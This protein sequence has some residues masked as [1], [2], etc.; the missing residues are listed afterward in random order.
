MT[1]LRK[2][3]IDKETGLPLVSASRLKLY[4]QCAKLY[5]YKYLSTGDEKPNIYAIHGS[6][7][8][9]AI[10]TW[11]KGNYSNHITSKM[12][13]DGKMR[14]WQN[15]DIIGADQY[16]R[17]VSEGQK[18][19]ETFNKDQFSPVDIEK[20]FKL[21]YPNDN[22]PICIIRGFIDFTQVDSFIDW[23]SSK[24]KRSK[25]KIRSDIQ[26]IIYHWVFYR[27]YGYYPSYGIYYRL[28]DHK[29]IKVDGFDIQILDDLIRQFINDPMEYDMTL[30][31]DC[32]SYCGLRQYLNTQKEKERLIVDISNDIVHTG[33]ENVIR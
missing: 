12:M 13:Y 11:Y 23:K 28:P 26:F 2:E 16:T 24:E 1:E 20:Y 4:Q 30:C 14:P 27:L 10:E 32:A 7:L 21:K 5:K 6:A 22:D 33:L 15:K 25:N 8:H 18:T 17:L 3:I 31:D 19:L 9:K 29:A